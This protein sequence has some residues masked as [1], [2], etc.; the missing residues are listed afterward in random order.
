M[1]NKLIP[2]YTRDLSPDILNTPP[3]PQI[4]VGGK[5][6]VSKPIPTHTH[7]L[8]PDI[9][10]TPL[11]PQGIPAGG[12]TN[13]HVYNVNLR[14]TFQE[15]HPD[16][17]LAM[18][19]KRKGYPNIYGARIPV[20]SGWKL[21]Y[22]QHKLQNYHDNVVI[23]FLRYGWPA[24]RLPHTLPPTVNT[25]NH[26]SASDFPETI[27]KYIDKETQ[28]GAMFGPFDHIH[29]QHRVGVSPLST[30][31]KK[32]PHKRRVIMDL[33]FADGTSVNDHIP[34]DSYLGLHTNVTY[35][36]VDDLAQRIADIGPTCLIFKRDLA[37][38]FRQVPLDPG[39]YDFFGS[40]WQEQFYFDKVLVM[41]HRSAPYIM[42]RI[43]DAITYL[44]CTTGYWLKNYIDDF[45]GAE[46]PNTAWESFNELEKEFNEMGVQEAPNKAVQ[47]APIVEFLEVQFNTPKGT[48]EVTPEKM[49][50]AR[51]ITAEWIDKTTCTRQELKQLI[52]KLQFIAS[53]VR[54]GRIFISRLLNELRNM[55]RSTRYQ[56]TYQMKQDVKWWNIFLPMY[57]GV[58]IM[59]P[60]Q[61][62]EVDYIIATDACPSGLGGTCI[63]EYF[64]IKVRES[65]RGY[66]IAYLEVL[67]VIVA[68]KIWKDK[69]KGC[70][71]VMHCDNLSVVQVLNS[72]RSRDM[73][74]QGAMREVAFLAAEGEFQVHLVHVPG[75]TNR[76]PDW[77]SRWYMG[78][79]VSQPKFRD[80]ARGHGLKH[81]IPSHSSLKFTHNW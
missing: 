68:L 64:H 14:V 47:P 2:T 73:F 67:A 52:G 21:T 80:H 27:Q 8:T 33:S 28:L 63:N 81:I 32:D 24:N 77:L 31:E 60:H 18:E 70:R 40:W 49:A 61:F 74:L 5:I 3:H 57:N 15:L 58:S 30:R 78:D 6:M 29:F 20:E 35:P 10:K 39:D 50:D 34:K 11:H 56:V 37:R 12:K 72:G 9:L 4:P 42:Q 23:E 51:M 65:Y 71:I 13:V 19:V 44:H 66:N 75:V 54:P 22:L 41:G 76:V 26:K 43:T 55:D 1:V 45:V 53:C 69:I 79:G 36:T 25:Q 46:H 62:D 59:W 48:M 16:I 7:E 17:V 38:A